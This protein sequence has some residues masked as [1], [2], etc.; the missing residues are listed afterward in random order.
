MPRAAA[1]PAVVLTI[2]GFDPTSGAGI[3]ADIKAIAANDG[4]GVACITALTVQNTRET[5]AFHP[6][7]AALLAEQLEF[8]L[9]DVQPQAVKIGMLGTA[10][11]VRTVAQALH[12]HPAPWVVLDP[13]IRASSGAR[14]LDDEGVEVMKRELLPLVSVM[15]PNLMEAELL[16][17]MPVHTLADM[18][19]AAA[20]LRRLGP[21]CAIITGGHLE[22]P[23]DLLDDGGHVFTFTAERVRTG[24]THG[25]GCTFS[26]ALAANL[27]KGKPVRD[28]VVLAKAYVTAA[29]KNSYPVGTGHGPLNHLYRLRHPAPLKNV[30]PAPLPEH[31]TR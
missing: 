10:E 7:D 26:A 4:Y 21:P 11:T 18:E 6:V 9:S 19:H 1:T 12:R 30:D 24:N 28:A 3:T 8:L 31:T 29:L 13:I 15:T 25:T 23:M 20:G 5:R 17:G 27:A 22:K 2:A 14:L 16:A